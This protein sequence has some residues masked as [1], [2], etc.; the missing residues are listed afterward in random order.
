MTMKI[1]HAASWV[2][3]LERA[4]SFYERWFE[5]YERPKVFE[6]EAALH[7]LLSVTRLGRT[8]NSRRTQPPNVLALPNLISC[9][10]KAPVVSRIYGRVFE[11]RTLVPFRRCSSSIYRNSPHMIQRTVGGGD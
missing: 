5:A 11:L 6:H 1:D 10:R 7:V 9:A 4:C 8:T 2:C 3:D